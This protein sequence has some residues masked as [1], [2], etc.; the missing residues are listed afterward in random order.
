MRFLFRILSLVGAAFGTKDVVAAYLLTALAA[1]FDVGILL[2]LRLI[3][4]LVCNG[5]DPRL[6]RRLV[7]NGRD[8]RLIRRLVCNGRDLRLIGGIVCSGC[9]RRRNDGLASLFLSRSRRS[10]AIA[11]SQR[12]KGKGVLTEGVLYLVDG[13]LTDAETSQV[14]RRL[15]K[16]LRN[17]VDAV[18]GK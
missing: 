15:F 14:S 5:C 9:G 10:F 4:R 17:V 3:G 18:F 16:K 12:L 7:C 2:R 11:C 1:E 8:P 13:D 6:I